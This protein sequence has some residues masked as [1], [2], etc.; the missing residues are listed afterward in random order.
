MRSLAIFISVVLVL[1][2]ACSRTP[3]SQLATTVI[4]SPSIVCGSCVKTIQKA[5]TQ[6]KGVKEVTGDPKAKTISVKYESSAVTLDQLEN[7][8][9]RAGYD[10]NGKKRDQSAYDKLDACCKIDG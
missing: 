4:Q 1:A 7:T 6:V 8:I 5:L 2:A 10:A 9:T 3:Q